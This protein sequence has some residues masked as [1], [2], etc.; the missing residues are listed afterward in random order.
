MSPS[1]S[2]NGL[3]LQEVGDFQHLGSAEIDEE[4]Q[5]LMNHNVSAEY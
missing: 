2:A 4:N 1:M 3:Q 5:T